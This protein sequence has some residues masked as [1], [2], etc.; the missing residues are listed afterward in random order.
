MKFEGHFGKNNTDN[1]R[2]FKVKNAPIGK[3]EF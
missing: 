1:H 3:T 2:T